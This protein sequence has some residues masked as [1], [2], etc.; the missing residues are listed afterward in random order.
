MFASRRGGSIYNLWEIS[1]SGGQPERLTTAER[2]VYSPTISRQANRL[3]YTQSL[4]DGN[5]WRIGLRN[6]RAQDESPLKLI[7]STQEESGPQ[8]SPDGKR[9]VFASRRSG[10]FEI[11]VCDS[12]GTNVRQLTNIG[13]PLT[14][15]P[16][17]S[18]DGREIAF[19][20]WVEGNA[21]IY[22]IAAEGGKPRRLTFDADEDVTPSWSRDGHWVY[23]GC[24]RSGSMQIWKVPAEGGPAVQITKQGGFEGFESTDGRY[25]YYAKGRATPGIWRVPA[26]GGEETPVLN[27]HQV[28]LW[29]Y[30][31]IT[32][33]GI[34]FATAQNP[35]RTLIE[36]FNLETGNVTPV[37]RI[38]KPLFKTD[39]GL[40]V[41]PDGQSLLLLQMDQSGSDIVLAENF[42]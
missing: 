24:T 25:F 33:R 7:S 15:T 22:V 35:A 14:G 42:R 19:D 26:G 10:S 37:A 13:G 28:G 40:A 29:R 30:W 38:D 1:T 3:A 34:Y 23:F 4:T 36:F 16:R 32:D 41:S 9:I 20:S 27:E 5:I 2:D 11:S 21:D 31:A 39:P 12:D 18:P 17:W 8:Y 6:F